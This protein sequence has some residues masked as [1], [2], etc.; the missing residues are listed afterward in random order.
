MKKELMKLCGARIEV[1]SQF[2]GTV[3][4]KEEGRR[5]KRHKGNVKDLAKRITN[6]WKAVEDVR[7]DAKVTHLFFVTLFLSLL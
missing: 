3:L 1:D 2:D 7:T 5:K 6:S 4:I